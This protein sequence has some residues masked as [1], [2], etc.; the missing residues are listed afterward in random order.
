MNMRKPT[1]SL[2]AR[3]S[4]NSGRTRSINELQGKEML[5]RDLL[6]KTETGDGKELIQVLPEVTFDHH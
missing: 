6:F 4:Q 1:A 3:H 5:A 2:A